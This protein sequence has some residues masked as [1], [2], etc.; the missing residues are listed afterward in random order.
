MIEHTSTS[1]IT[2][3]LGSLLKNLCL[4]TFAA[5]YQELAE[6]FELEKKTYTD[7][8]HE[9]TVREMEHRHNLRI[10]RLLKQAKLSRDKLL[11][12]FDI[13]RIPG[14]SPAKV[15][16]LATGEFIDATENLLIFGNPGTGK[17]HLSIGL[18]REWCLRGRRVLYQT[19]ASLVQQLLEAKAALKLRQFI[20]KLDYMEVLLIDDISYVP[21]TR[22]ETDVLFTLLAERY[23]TRS[24]VITSNLA[25]ANWNSIFKDEMTTS[26]AIDRLVHH[27]TI[28]ELNAESYR[29]EAAKNKKL[30]LAQEKTKNGETQTTQTTKQTTKEEETETK[31]AAEITETKM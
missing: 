22:A 17:T 20:K 7:Y 2:A 29:V 24:V 5:D 19:A 31:K 9:L 16:H 18:A 27:S 15:Q 12:S 1:T 30:A 10:A 14:L 23:E 28:L 25:F 11:I 4:P 3:P 13:K 8:L 6:S 26:A 21:Y